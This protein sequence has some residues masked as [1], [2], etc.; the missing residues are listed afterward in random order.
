MAER[1]S[2]EGLTPCTEDGD[3]DAAGPFLLVDCS[4]H[5]PIGIFPASSHEYDD[6]E[7][8]FADH[9]DAISQTEQVRLLAQKI[10]IKD[11]HLLGYLDKEG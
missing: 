7:L 2:R 6:A 9:V 10:V 11:R 8:M 1:C 5:G 3:P 4:V